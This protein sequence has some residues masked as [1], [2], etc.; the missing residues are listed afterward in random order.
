MTM[1]LVMTDHYFSKEDLKQMGLRLR[2]GR[3]IDLD[4]DAKEQFRAAFRKAGF[5]KRATYFDKL[6]R[7]EK[8]AVH[9]QEIHT[10]HIVADWLRPTPLILVGS[11]KHQIEESEFGVV[12]IA[13]KTSG[14]K[15]GDRF[16]KVLNQHDAALLPFFTGAGIWD[17]EAI[18]LATNYLSF[19]KSLPEN[20]DSDGN[21]EI[22]NMLFRLGS[23]G[24]FKIEVDDT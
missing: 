2:S 14:W 1:S 16:F 15:G 10:F 11:E 7:R 4:E 13:A 20:D 19:V 3:S 8:P 5:I 12:L 21:I 9:K 24:G 23:S 18:Q 6:F 22:A 17:D